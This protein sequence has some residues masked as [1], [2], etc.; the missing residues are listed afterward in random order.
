MGTE[1]WKQDIDRFKSEDTDPNAKER[2]VFSNTI[3]SSL[4]REKRLNQ[5][6]R[7]V[8]F[9][10]VVFPEKEIYERVSLDQ[11]EIVNP[12]WM[13]PLLM[14]SANKPPQEIEAFIGNHLF[15]VINNM[16]F[17]CTDVDYF[18]VFKIPSVLIAIR[19]MLSKI[20]N[21]DSET[22]LN[23]NHLVRKGIIEQTDKSDNNPL[24]DLYRGIAMEINRDKIRELVGINA[25]G[26]SQYEITHKAAMY[27]CL[28]RYGAFDRSLITNVMRLNSTLASF[29]NAP[30]IFNE[31]ILIDIYQILFDRLDCL[32]LGTMFDTD[33]YNINTDDPEVNDRV[34]ESASLQVNAVLAL[35][36]SC[37]IPVIENIL[38]I[39]NDRFYKQKNGDIN[40]IRASMRSL[41]PAD[42]PTLSMVV[43]SLCQ[44][45]C[46]I[47]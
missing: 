12:N 8:P 29:Q 11:S 18:P 13:M 1:Y 19:M 4:E 16:V 15:S 17:P 31:Q 36:D 30:L 38:I 10:G 42:Y 5:K 14:N 21:F 27:I 41:S 23:V 35:L 7:P 33:I 46:F 34:S 45:G 20:S 6:V 2:I 47:P 32:V 28:S 9:Q 43:E 22:I 26:H 37:A 24:M 39:Y 25:R 40:Q 44:R 3:E